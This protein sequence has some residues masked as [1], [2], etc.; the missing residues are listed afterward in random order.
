M[1]KVFPKKQTGMLSSFKGE[2]IIIGVE[3]KKN[4]WLGII[5]QKL[6]K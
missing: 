4:L 2:G 1:F 3:G 5:A 6:K